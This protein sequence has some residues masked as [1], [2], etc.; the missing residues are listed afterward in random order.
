MATIF[1]LGNTPIDHPI[2]LRGQ[3]LANFVRSLAPYPFRVLHGTVFDPAPIYPAPIDP[4][5]ISTIEPFNGAPIASDA[6]WAKLLE[7]LPPQI[8]VLFLAD[9]S[10]WQW[11][12]KIKAQPAYRQ[13]R[14]VVD[15]SNLS[16]IPDIFAQADHIFVSSE[17]AYKAA[18]NSGIRA[19]S[20]VRDGVY[21]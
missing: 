4:N 5:T 3:R 12:Q 14:L 18:H 13:T 15:L 16:D 19:I 9:S 21:P 8:E 11:A 1:F 2:G 20:L 6:I 10:L 17:Q 7:Q